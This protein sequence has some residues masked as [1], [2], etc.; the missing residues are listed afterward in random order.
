MTVS[1]SESVVVHPGEGT[2]H[3]SRWPGCSCGREPETRQ[4]S[5]SPLATCMSG[6]PHPHLWDKSADDASCH[7][8]PCDGLREMVLGPHHS[9]RICSHRPPAL[10]CAIRGSA[11]G[12]RSLF[13]HGC[14]LSRPLPLTG[15]ALVFRDQTWPW[16]WLY[17]QTPEIERS[18]PDSRHSFGGDRR[19]AAHTPL[20]STLG[21]PAFS[22]ASIRQQAPY[23]A[24]LSGPGYKRGNALSW[25][26]GEEGLVIRNQGIS[27]GHLS[28]QQP[29]LSSS[30]RYPSVL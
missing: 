17:G 6:I 2:G 3:R 14:S 19:C 23:G 11:C 20:G 29:S 9:R 25:D 18:I 4:D 27:A 22:S 1:T 30:E 21:R 26:S 7:C 16:P 8:P 24:L 5:D 28:F 15:V 13:D 10:P 12:C